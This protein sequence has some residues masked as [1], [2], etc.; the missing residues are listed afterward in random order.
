MT[1]WL[2]FSDRDEAVYILRQRL[3]PKALRKTVDRD[4]ERIVVTS[5]R[6]RGLYRSSLADNELPEFLVDLHGVDLLQ[7]KKLRIE[8]IK[9]LDDTQI[10][11]LATW[12]D[13][14]PKRTRVAMIEQIASRRWHPGKH[15]ARHFATIFGLPK[16]Y[17][18]VIGNPG[19]PPYEDV[20]PYIPLPVLHDYQAELVT[21]LHQLLSAVEGKNRALLSLPTGAGKTRT[22][23]E[24]LLSWW[25]IQEN[26]N[27][28]ILWI[29][30]SDELCEQAIEAF[31]EVW[32]DCGGK[33]SRK[34]LR[35]YRCWGDY[36]ALPETYGD[37]VVVASIQ[38]LYEMLSTDDGSE[39]LSNFADDVCAII[40]DEAHHAVASSYT[41][42]METFG[43]T[44][45]RS[46]AT[47]IPLIGL[48]A[49]P[50]RSTDREENF[51]L[52]R[53]FYNQLLIPSLLR[54]EPIRLLRERKILSQ[55]EHYI[56]ETGCHFELNDAEEQ[57]YRQIG[58]LPDSF[59]RKVG[60]DPERN[61][62]LL[63][64][65]LNLPTD[66]PILFFGCSVEHAS[67]FAILL[68]R[69]QRTAA[70]ITGTTRRA[71]RRHLIDE[72]RAGRIQVLCNYGVLTTGFDAPKIRAVVIARPT[73]SVVLYEQMIGRG[74]RGPLNGGTDVCTVID[75][76]D[77]ISR[78]EGQMAYTRMLDAWH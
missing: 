29:A 56:L 37:G 20:E 15:W 51:R 16:V 23:V 13:D 57:R 36:N 17:A 60:A 21:K 18:G 55:V 8:L 26:T 59:L 70:V 12:G 73:T 48:S 19:G 5:E 49:T 3:N 53:R 64:A 35:L 39:H 10:S 68:R 50:Y 46:P 31:R 25:G 47:P 30:Q 7:N 4:I 1:D 62:L 58:Q 61:N 77:N 38:K 40:V 11:S 71:T 28:Y 78:F 67:A 54:E 2:K 41:A 34:I 32:I 44:F 43:I 75:L 65:I 72:F 63:K 52:A 9:T 66:W 76:A 74:M 27:P 45:G 42:V 33:G 24:A 22:A 6:I 69:A 14:S